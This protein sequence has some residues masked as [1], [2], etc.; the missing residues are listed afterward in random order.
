MAK[1][2]WDDQS[3][4]K[5]CCWFRLQVQRCAADVLWDR[6]QQDLASRGGL[7][8]QETGPH[9]TGGGVDARVGLGTWV[10]HKLLSVKGVP[11]ADGVTIIRKNHQQGSRQSF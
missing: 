7:P 4:N 3:F 9:Q 6:N 2:F 10:C 11:S 8:P 5:W 1:C